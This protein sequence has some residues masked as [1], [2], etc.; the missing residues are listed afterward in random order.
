MS[1]FLKRYFAGEV[2]SENN[3][4]MFV[5]SFL[6]YMVLRSGLGS[7][8]SLHCPSVFPAWEWLYGTAM[9]LS[10]Q[11]IS[12]LSFWNLCVWGGRGYSRTL[13]SYLQVC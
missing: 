2:G 3:F 4:V 8:D 12:T 6:L 13:K 9:W 1:F 10:L 5:S 7:S 11:A